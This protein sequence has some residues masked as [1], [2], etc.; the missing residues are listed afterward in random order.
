MK[1]LRFTNSPSLYCLWNNIGKE[2]TEAVT[3]DKIM[4]SI[5]ADEDDWDPGLF[6]WISERNFNFDGWQETVILPINLIEH[7]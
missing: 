2:V 5:I 1:V 7:G 4:K 3:Y 6:K